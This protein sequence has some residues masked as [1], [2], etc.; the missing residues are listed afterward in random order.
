MEV[1]E[2]AKA[3]YQNNSIVKHVTISFPDSSVP[4]IT[5][6]RIYFETMKLY[7]SVLEDDSLEFV[8][9]IAS[10]FSIQAY[11]VPDDIKGRYMTVMVHTD[12]TEDEPI[13]VFNGVV[14]SAVLAANK[15]YKEITAYDELYTKGGMDIADW[16]K[17]QKFPMALKEFRDSLFEYLSVTQAECE[18]PN[19]QMTVRKTY[20][21]QSMKALGVIKSICQINGV[22]GIINRNGEFEYRFPPQSSVE[23]SEH[24]D[25]YKTVEHE[26]FVTKK[27]GR[28]ILR[29]SEN[30]IGVWNTMHSEKT[31]GN[32]GEGPGDKS[33]YII[34]GNMFTADLKKPELQNV[35]DNIYNTVKDFS[36]QPFNTDNNGLPWVECG[37]NYVSYSMLTDDSYEDYKDRTFFVLKREMTG[38]QTMRDRYSAEGE[39]YLSEFVTNIDAEIGNLEQKYEEL[40]ASKLVVYTYENKDEYKIGPDETTIIRIVYAASLDTVPLFA[41]TIP[42]EMEGGGNIVLKYYDGGLYLEQQTLTMYLAKGRHFVT[43]HNF[44]SVEKD[45]QKTLRV[46]ICTESAV[47]G[48]TAPN[49]GIKAGT[50][51]ASL[52]GNGLA[53]TTGWDGNIDISEQ[54]AGF[55]LGNI[56]VAGFSGS[57]N[58][59]SE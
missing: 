29:N 28:V 48:G 6:D 35:A 5:L 13:T 27:I 39:Q 52:F 11:G 31:D 58:V 17:T 1:S 54:H 7:E 22:W 56:K 24:V 16:Y 38:I 2:A 30:D 50:I 37:V 40:V 45:I 10:K 42:L 21:P 47:D 53:S 44:F 46:S 25:F 20:D 23:N 12:G 33:K 49:G 9:C 36:Y 34:V 51:R 55:R 14:D 18:L 15:K 43:L 26:E 32:G 8:G 19:D 4:D 3:A 57:V 59:D 41:A